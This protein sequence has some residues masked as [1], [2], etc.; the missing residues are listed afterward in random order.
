MNKLVPTT[1]CGRS[2]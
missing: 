2:I 1:F